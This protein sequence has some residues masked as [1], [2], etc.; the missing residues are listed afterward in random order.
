M[1][2]CLEIE[3]QENSR[4]YCRVK[5]WE[6]IRTPSAKANH[7]YDCLGGK[8][9]WSVVAVWLM[10]R[11]NWFRMW[12]R[13][14]SQFWWLTLANWLECALV[15]TLRYIFDDWCRD[16]NFIYAARECTC[17]FYL[18]KAPT[19]LPRMWARIWILLQFGWLTG[20]SVN[21]PQ[22]VSLSVWS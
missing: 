15:C 6:T 2:A 14:S 10:Q 17:S 5:R 3:M 18:T 7:V 22:R 4:K 11:P 19:N 16:P 9:A 8:L 13:I 21:C 12:A 1:S 20:L